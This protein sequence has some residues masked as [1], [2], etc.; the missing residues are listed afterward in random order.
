MGSG[1]EEA[2]HKLTRGAYTNTYP[3]VAFKSS[4]DLEAFDCNEISFDSAGG[5]LTP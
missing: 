4:I 1:T 3:R 5:V 2:E